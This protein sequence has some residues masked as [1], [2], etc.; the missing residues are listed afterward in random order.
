[1]RRKL[2]YRIFITSN[3]SRIY[4]FLYVSFRYKNASQLITLQMLGELR[5]TVLFYLLNVVVFGVFNFTSDNDFYR[6]FGHQTHV[7]W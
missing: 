7:T 1:M 3:V 6:E 2:Y 5:A 4:M